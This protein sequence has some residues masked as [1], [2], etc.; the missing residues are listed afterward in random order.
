MIWL[1][2]ALAAPP[3]AQVGLLLGG[4][5]APES[6]L[7]VA[8]AGAPTEPGETPASEL[9]PSALAGLEGSVTLRHDSGVWASLD[10][11]AWLLVPESEADRVVL[12]PAVGWSKGER[13]RFDLA[14]RYRADLVPLRSSASSGRIEALAR[15]SATG[16]AHTV[17]L[18]ST[19][20]DRHFYTEPAWSF[21]ALD[22]GATWRL[23]ADGVRAA[24]G[25]S[26]QVN[27][28]VRE[29]GEALEAEHLG[30]QARGLA[31]VGLNRG[32]FDVEVRY[33]P[34]LA[35]AGEIEDDTVRPV[36]GPLG[37]YAED[38]DAVSGGGFV[39][40]RLDV[41]GAMVSGGWTVRAGALGRLR[42]GSGATGLVR[43]GHA[44]LGAERAL[45]DHWA[46]V[47]TVG[48]LAA[49]LT[50]G[51]GFVDVYGWGGV[52]WRLR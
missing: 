1:T 15:V 39:Q 37:D 51:T 8:P 46:L 2:G 50:G 44:H 7:Q 27:Q 41:E 17:E 49:E 34:I 23:D 28:G 29:A 14:G 45:G 20:V 19:F 38:V 13:T 11:T 52:R 9:E 24:V 48:I 5:S 16:G 47:G 26:F 36:I 42:D 43:T 25:A 40:H 21:R 4:R 30:T 6:T 33:R 31:S 22:T 10:G 32:G 3:E 18:A 12:G 35:F